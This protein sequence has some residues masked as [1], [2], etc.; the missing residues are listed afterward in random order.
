MEIPSQPSKKPLEEKNEEESIEY[1]QKIIEA[2]QKQ[3]EQLEK[4]MRWCEENGLDP[5]ENEFYLGYSRSRF[6]GGKYKGKKINICHHDEYPS[7][8]QI[9]IEGEDILYGREYH[10][11]AKEIFDKLAPWIAYDE[12]ERA[13]LRRNIEIHN[14]IVADERRMKAGIKA[15]LEQIEKMEP[16]R[17][18]VLRVLGMDPSSS[19]E[20]I[21]N[22]LNEIIKELEEVE[23]PIEHGDDLQST[24]GI[25]VAIGTLTKRREKLLKLLNIDSSQISLEA[26]SKIFFSNK[27]RDERLSFY[28]EYTVTQKIIKVDGEINGEKVLL[29]CENIF[30]MNRDGSI[31]RDKKPQ[32]PTLI[33]FTEKLAEHDSFRPGEGEIGFNMKITIG[34]DGQKEYR[35]IKETYRSVGTDSERQ[36]FDK[37]NEELYKETQELL[38]IFFNLADYTQVLEKHIENTT[39]QHQ[40]AVEKEKKDAEEKEKKSRET[41]KKIDDLLE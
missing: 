28:D 10:E 20:E 24:E 18:A 15:R 5:K 12:R 21:K 33:E 13:V 30:Y 4:H 16:A 32:G 8:A 1:S 25:Q 31:G 6:I 27:E 19:R 14:K 35:W 9:E 29:E 39:Y 34:E 2:M 7:Y 37:E 17:Q 40:Q 41:L 23:F 36:R 26:D 3:S 11:K 22:K 38:W